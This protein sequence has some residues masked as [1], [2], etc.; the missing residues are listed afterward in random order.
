MASSLEKVHKSIG[1]RP[2]S[3][4]VSLLLSLLVANDFI[5][6]AESNAGYVESSSK[7][8]S[9]PRLLRILK[10]SAVKHVDQGLEF[11]FKGFRSLEQGRVGTLI[12]EELVTAA[13]ADF[14]LPRD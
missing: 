10:M 5:P 2:T 12:G 13:P 6:N 3:I 8:N 14:P 4:S 11:F 7:D 9:I 1:P